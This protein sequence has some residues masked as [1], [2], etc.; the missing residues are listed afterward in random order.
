MKWSEVF[1]KLIG[2]NIE[3][4]V[5]EA[6]L[7]ALGLKNGVEKNDEGKQDDKNKNTININL[8]N[9]GQSKQEDKKTEPEVDKKEQDDMDYKTIKFDQKSGLFDLSNIENEDL[10]SVLKLANDT[11][12]NTANRVKI[13]AA[14]NQK[15]AGVKLHK[16]I[17]VD[18][19]KSLINMDNVKVGDDGK[20]SGL[21]EAF[22]ELQKSQSGLFVQGKSNESTPV[23]EGYHPAGNNGGDNSIDAALAS[24]ASELTAVN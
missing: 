10:K 9:P 14:F 12:T 21:D 6:S 22:S 1:S 13:D 7:T 15:M 8:A 3:D 24:L 2:K 23:M 19:V 18:A 17:T 20:V 16:G 11:V 5:D 4:E